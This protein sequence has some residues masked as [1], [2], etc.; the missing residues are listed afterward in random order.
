MVGI[1]YILGSII[2]DLHIFAALTAAI[3]LLALVCAIREIMNS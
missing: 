2:A 1:E 3:Y